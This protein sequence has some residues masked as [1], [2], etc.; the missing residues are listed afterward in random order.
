MDR[1]AWWAAVHGVAQSQTRLKRLSSSSSKQKRV[2]FIVEVLTLLSKL[3]HTARLEVQLALHILGF[4]IHRFNQSQIKN[5]WKKALDST[6]QQNL[7]LLCS[8]NYF[9]NRFHC[10]YNYLRSIYIALGI[11]TY[12]G[13]CA[14]C[15]MQILCHFIEG[16]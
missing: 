7:N 16:T 6:S 4:C 1:G 14:V 9:I 8:S 12:T 2:N 5:I 13:G 11:I 3:L 10:I 15:Y